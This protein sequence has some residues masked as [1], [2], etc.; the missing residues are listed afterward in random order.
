MSNLKFSDVANYYVGK[1]KVT[2]IRLD[3]SEFID[4]KTQTN[5]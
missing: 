2:I 5:G 3:E 1:I 4:E